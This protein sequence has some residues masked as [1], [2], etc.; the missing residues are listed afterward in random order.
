MPDRIA[1][2][3]GS[4]DPIHHGH[5][6]AARAVRER[7]D[8]DQVIFLPSGTPPHKPDHPLAAP[9][10]RLAMLKLAI[11]GEPGFEFSDYDLNRGGPSYTLETVTHFREILPDGVELFW[12]VGG[13]S[14]RALHT[15]YKPDQIASLCRIVTAARPGFEPGDLFELRSLLE[16]DHFKQVLADV[17]ETPRIEI[18]ATDIRRRAAAGQSIRFLVPDTVADYIRQRNLY[19][20]L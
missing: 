13:D 2:F 14:L 20:R 9:E 1:L 4:F 19:A 17:L 18:S 12:I 5:L 11:A 8:L 7:L 10:H 16:P 3:G 6:I 15:W